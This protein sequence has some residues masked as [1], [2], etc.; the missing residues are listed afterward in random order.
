M[1]DIKPF[2]KEQLENKDFINKVKNNVEYALRY[3]AGIYGEELVQ[4]KLLRIKLEESL[5]KHRSFI[6]KDLRDKYIDS[7]VKL[8]LTQLNSLLNRSIIDLFEKHFLKILKTC[9]E[10][11]IDF[12]NKIR[13][14][15]LGITEVSK[16]DPFIKDI[17]ETLKENIEVLG[18]ERIELKSSDKSKDPSIKNWLLDYDYNVGAGKHNGIDISNYLFKSKN[19][20]K[21]NSDN[22]KILKEILIFYEKLKLDKYHPNSFSIPSSLT[23]FGIKEVGKGLDKKYMPL[24]PNDKEYQKEIEKIK[25]R[26]KVR[27]DKMK[28]IRGEK[29]S[30]NKLGRR[31][32]KARTPYNRPLEPVNDLP[33]RE[34]A[35]EKKKSEKF[36]HLTSI[37]KSSIAKLLNPQVIAKLTVEDFRSFGKDAA[38]AGAF[39]ATKLKKL[40]ENS[41]DNKEAIK[42]YLR[43]SELYQVY[44]LQGRESLDSKKDMEKIA[45]ERKKK[46]EKYV[47][48]KEFETLRTVLKSI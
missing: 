46:G 26:K 5:R 39:M 10:E 20:R 40:S 36:S 25:A 3:D 8:S 16:R 33:Q 41:P 17:K 42:H 37:S 12:N 34:S 47:T 9:L 4:L 30:D 21:L 32:N 48:K 18:K 35:I 43:R 28:I 23:S 22:K 27:K 31:D 24:D 14:I 38:S 6:N 29:K 44:L 15:V 11:G 7:I 2:T 13:A 19:A 1:K 45:E